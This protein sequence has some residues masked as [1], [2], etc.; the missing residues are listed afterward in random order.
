MMNLQLADCLV[1]TA[2]KYNVAN[3]PPLII[4]NFLSAL[5]DITIGV[6]SPNALLRLAKTTKLGE[7][8]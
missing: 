5:G 6:M 3:T 7:I 8:H 1:T 4:I 2:T